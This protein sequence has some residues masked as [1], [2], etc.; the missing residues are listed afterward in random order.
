MKFYAI[1][2][3]AEYLSNLQFCVSGERINIAG[4][5]ENKMLVH[6]YFGQIERAQFTFIE[7]RFC[8]KN[9]FPRNM[10]QNR[11][12]CGVNSKKAY[13]WYFFMVS[14]ESLP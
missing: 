7:E 5:F 10:N 11:K 2:W 14:C 9:A 8:A 12:Y 3:T 4:V 1:V 6:I 13:L